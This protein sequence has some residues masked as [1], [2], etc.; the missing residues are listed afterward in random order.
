MFAP[1]LTPLQKKTSRNHSLTL[2][3]QATVPKLFVQISRSA[4]IASRSFRKRENVLGIGVSV[5]SE[6]LKPSLVSVSVPMADPSLLSNQIQ[7]TNHSQTH[8][9][10][11]AIN[12]HDDENTMTNKRVALAIDAILHG[13]Q[14]HTSCRDTARRKT[15][16]ALE[17]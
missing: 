2:T 15:V 5:G 7:S 1:V 13:F 14:M 6:K 12:T 16:E 17:K 4:S 11:N 9:K 10:T 3:D 8:S